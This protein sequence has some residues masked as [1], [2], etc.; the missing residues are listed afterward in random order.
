MFFQ[1]SSLGVQERYL[2]GL[3]IISS[4]GEQNLCS[5]LGP[6]RQEILQ[7]PLAKSLEEKQ[8]KEDLRMPPFKAFMKAK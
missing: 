4:L 8:E 1:E 5:A 2:R 3:S 6:L 7:P